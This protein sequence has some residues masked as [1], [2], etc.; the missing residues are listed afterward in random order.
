M[1]RAAFLGAQFV[2]QLSRRKLENV[3]V[4]WAGAS[5]QLF[6]AEVRAL[7]PTIAVVDL[8]EFT[9]GSD[10][11]VRA[12]VAGCGAELA[13]VTYSFARRQLIR[14]L[15]SQQVRV[16][17]SPIT[18]DVLQAHFAP[19]IIR[20]VLESARREV[21]SMEQSPL[22]PKY[23]REQ[24]GKLME[25]TSAIECECPNHVAQLVEKLQAFERYSK[26]CENRDDADRAVHASLYKSS[27]VARAEMEKALTMLIAHE[28]IQI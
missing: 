5:P 23:T 9:A 25:I 4:V 8:A 1:I 10:D 18:L 16:L 15:Q 21:S 7:K 12:L 17:P 22:P 20:H 14:S 6:A 11:E 2:G 3:E 27:A 28:K 13:I 24:L 19:F 26:D